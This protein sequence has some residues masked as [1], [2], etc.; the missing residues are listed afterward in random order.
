MPYIPPKRSLPSPSEQ[1]SANSNWPPTADELAQYGIEA[2]ES[3]KGPL[4]RSLPTSSEQPGAAFNW[5]PTDDELTQYGI[6]TAQD[7]ETEPVFDSTGAKTGE[8]PLASVALPQ[9]DTAHD[10]NSPGEWAAEMARLQALI[11][12]LTQPVEWRIRSVTED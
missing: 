11:A 6:E 10:G 8:P 7:E 4:R 9:S 3:D 12:A 1:P 5:P 2:V